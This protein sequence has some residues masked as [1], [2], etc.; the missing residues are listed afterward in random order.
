[1][2]V[3]VSK[4]DASAERVV[5]AVSALF[6]IINA[7]RA[8]REWLEFVVTG[9]AE[10]HQPGERVEIPIGG[11]SCIHLVLVVPGPDQPDVAL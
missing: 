4:Q 7:G 3:T 5:Q 1:M 2:A 9:I 6:G 10:T 11:G 8:F